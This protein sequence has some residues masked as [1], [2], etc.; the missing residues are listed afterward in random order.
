MKCAR[1]CKIR[2]FAARDMG[3]P[4]QRLP[5]GDPEPRPTEEQAKAYIAMLSSDQS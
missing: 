2:E 4:Q 1:D 5:R 3:F